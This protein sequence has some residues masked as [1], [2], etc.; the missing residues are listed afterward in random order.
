[1]TELDDLA[2]ELVSSVK[3][4]Y[5]GGTLHAMA[6]AGNRHSTIAVNHTGELRTR[7]KGRPCQPF[8]FDTKVHIRLPTHTRY[9]YP[10]A[11]RRVPLEPRD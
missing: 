1:M 3:H 10:D 7:L 4:E 5:I 11:F 6:G 2:G 8:N 9:Y